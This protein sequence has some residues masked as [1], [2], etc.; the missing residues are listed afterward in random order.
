M[1]KNINECWKDYVKS[2]LALS[3]ADKKA[4]LEWRFDVKDTPEYLMKM[5]TPDGVIVARKDG[6]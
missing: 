2:R 5:V 4:M 1:K 3:E 6:D